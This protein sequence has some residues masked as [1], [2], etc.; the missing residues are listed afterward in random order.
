RCRPTYPRGLPISSDNK[1]LVVGIGPD[2]LVP[3]NTRSGLLGGT[4]SN[5][6]R[7]H[8]TPF[9]HS[10]SFPHIERRHRYF[11]GIFPGSFSTEPV[12][13]ESRPGDEYILCRSF[14][15]NPRLERGGSAKVIQINSDSVVSRCLG[16]LMGCRGRR[17]ECNQTP[18][19]ARLRF[20]RECL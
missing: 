14:L 18:L 12:A 19:L 9:P 11:T 10:L 8:S 6:P 16:L 20:A 1:R 15:G 7:C 5:R 13:G 2:S 3:G 4:P 17:G